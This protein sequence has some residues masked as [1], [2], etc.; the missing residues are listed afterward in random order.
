[1]RGTLLVLWVVLLLTLPVP[2]W[3]IEVG[4]VPTASLLALGLVTIGASIVEGGEVLP[5]LAL[6]LAVQ[7]IVWTAILYVAARL[8][9]RRIGRRRSILT[10]RALATVLVCGLAAMSLFDV[11]RAP[12]STSGPR[13]NVLGAFW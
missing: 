1:M 3:A 13:T 12:F 10:Q 7:S 8:V 6:V 2:Y 4:L 9:T 5:L 11:Y